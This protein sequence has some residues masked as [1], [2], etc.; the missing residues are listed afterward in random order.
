VL[1]VVIPT[2]NRR[3]TL[4]D[5]LAQV[6][7]QEV[8]RGGFEV[9]AVDNGSSDE[10]LETLADLERRS[11]GRL[12]ALSEPVRGPAAARNAGVAAAR[13]EV[14]VFLGDDTQP[15]D[16]QLLARHV[17]LHDARPEP[18]YAVLGKVAWDERRSV[19]PL[20]RWLDTGPQF[21]YELFSPGL[22]DVAG[23]FYTAHVSLKKAAF[24]AAGGFDT[25]FPY[26]AVEDME[27]G[28]RLRDGGV[29]LDYRPE[30]VVLHS[31]ETTLERWLERMRLVGR[32]AALLERMYPDNPS[33]TVS[34]PTGP[35]Y[36]AVRAAAPLFGRLDHPGAP[37]WFQKLRWRVLHHAAY[38]RGYRQG[39]PDSGRA[40]HGEPLGGGGS[41]ANNRYHRRRSVL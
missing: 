10:T 11:G 7:A 15:A 3:A 31:H 14:I 35:R 13:G 34:M 30:L 36:A 16:R 24:D 25:R 40:A 12:R 17:A 8:P 22:V 9:I 26:A 18:E 37:R 23:F 2:R 27:I 28:L 21:A 33:P 38:A 19:T 32:S 41:D 20:M 4:A 5:T 6:F 39:P 1:S 29:V